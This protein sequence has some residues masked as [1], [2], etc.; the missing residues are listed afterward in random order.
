MK[1]RK[2]YIDISP[3]EVKLHLADTPLPLFGLPVVVAVMALAII[4]QLRTCMKM[5]MENERERA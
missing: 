1:G 3:A 5:E 4:E 2:R